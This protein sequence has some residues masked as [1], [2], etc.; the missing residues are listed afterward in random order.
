MADSAHIATD[1]RIAAMER[2]LRG[3]YL[4]AKKEISEAWDIY[5]DDVSGEI[6]EMQ[7]EYEDAKRSGDK[8]EIKKTGKALEKKKR[9]RTIMDK[10]YKDVVERTVQELANVNAIATAYINGQL[11]PVYALN[12]NYIAKSLDSAIRG[13][14]FNL[15]NP[16]VVRL[17]IQRDEVKLPERKL[18][19]AKDKRWNMRKINAE[20]TQGIIQGESMQDIAARLA[21]VQT[22]N[23]NSA[24]TAARIIVTGTENQGRMDMLREAEEM[25]IIVKKRWIATKDTRT[26]DWHTELNG[27][28]AKADEPFENSAGRIMYPGDPSASAENVYN[29]RCTIGYEV[30]GFASGK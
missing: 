11:P 26:R 15:L 4:R 3:I 29:C 30:E 8:K 22:M 14:S 25:G 28:L 19:V 2:K 12:Y 20:V 1:K 27:K 9:E 13:Y 21:K 23:M 16:N 6:E 24:I 18:D 7:R 17:M 10:R 5:M